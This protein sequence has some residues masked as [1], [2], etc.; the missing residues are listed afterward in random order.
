MEAMAFHRGNLWKWVAVAS[1][2]VGGGGGEGWAASNPSPRFISVENQYLRLLLRQHFFVR[3]QQG[4]DIYR[5][6]RFSLMTTGGDPETTADD[7]RVILGDPQGSLWTSYTVIRVNGQDYE[8]ESMMNNWTNPGQDT[9]VRP[10]S[11]GARDVD[12]AWIIPEN[13]NGFT[14]V[15]DSQA[16]SSGGGGTTN[17]PGGARVL[18]EQR[19][20]LVRDAVRIEYRLTNRGPG[21]AD[22]GLRIF[23]D[24]AFGLTPNDGQPIRVEETG[25]ITTETLFPLATAGAGALV[26]RT[27]V[28]FDNFLAPASILS[29]LFRGADVST[30]RNS[31]GVPDQVI[32]GQF[33]LMNGITWDYV[34]LNNPLTGEDWAISIRWEPKRL[35]VNQTRVYVTYF[36]LGGATSDYTEPYVFAVEAPFSL[37]L[38]QGDDPSTLEREPDTH[39]FRSPSPFTIK[40]Y[41]MNISDVPLDGVVFSLSL[42]SGLELADPTESRT[43]TLASIPV[44][45][46]GSV[47]WRVVPTADLTP[48]VKSFVVSVSGLAL[49]AKTLTRSIEIPALPTLGIKEPARRLDMISVPFQIPNADIEHVLGSLGSIG[50]GGAGAAV[51]R[52]NPQTERYHFFPDAFITT[53][54]PGMGFWLFNASLR[55]ILLPDP[56]QRQAIPLTQRVAIPLEPGWNQIGC[57]YVYSTEWLN[58]LVSFEGSLFSLPEAA[59]AGLLRPTLYWYVPNFANPDQPGT[60][61]FSAQPGTLLEPWRGYWVRALRR[62]TLIITPPKVVGPFRSRPPVDLNAPP[63]AGWKVP[64]VVEAEGM[65][66]DRQWFGVSPG[67]ADGYD[68]L[69]IDQPPPLRLRG[70]VRLAFVHRDWGENSGCYLQDIRSPVAES[71]TWEFEVHTDLSQRPITLRWPQVQQVPGEYALYL[72]DLASGRRVSMRTQSAY[73]YLSEA[74]GGVRRFRIVVSRQRPSRL[75]VLRLEASPGRSGEAEV[76][77]ELSEPA[78]GWFEVARLNGQPVAQGRT[79]TLASRGTLRWSGRDTSG[80]PVPPGVY[81]MRVVFE[82]ASGERATAVRILSVAPRP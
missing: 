61:E 32:F 9:T 26:P 55:D 14:A 2:L 21:P 15:V 5:G 16:S 43:K 23:L 47:S 42:P 76:R 74:E 65:V 40:A 48:G 29:G 10:E 19:L 62:V 50:L 54:Q 58:A 37:A 39:V 31:A 46:E 20:F 8:I 34:P 57:P 36:G 72:E 45:R 4:F 51:A 33:R 12:Y 1:L 64:L 22:V 3:T 60:Y 7:N 66:E 68:P 82:N 73:T 13:A 81:M 70:F 41:A 56:D 6:G 11:A 63:P 18:V 28:S 35:E 75:R 30:V 53:I 17:T 25:E 80:R 67:A 49:P 69:D 59:R 77:Y 38:K 78:Q 71:K 52:W 79:E 27:W 44:N 24:P